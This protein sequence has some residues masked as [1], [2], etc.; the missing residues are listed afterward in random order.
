VW[1]LRTGCAR[2]TPR[3]APTTTPRIKLEL[4]SGV[5][6]ALAGLSQLE[7][8]KSQS[9][10]KMTRTVVEFTKVQEACGANY[11]ECRRCDFWTEDLS[12]IPTHYVS[13]HFDVSVRRY[14]VAS[15]TKPK[16]S[17]FN[18]QYPCWAGTELTDF[19][20]R[21]WLTMGLKTWKSRSPA[22]EGTIVTVA[23]R[24]KLLRRF[25]C[26]FCGLEGST[27]AEIHDHIVSRHIMFIEKLKT[28]V[29][30]KGEYLLM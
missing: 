17:H 5:K 9:N 27:K 24:E 21:Q 6:T 23:C 18:E 13:E 14:T 26:C 15:L 12:K 16:K 29:C 3:T 19:Q 7:D 30:N 11:F 8:K 25:Y 22:V 10:K 4:P 28:R 1:G 2:S 20:L